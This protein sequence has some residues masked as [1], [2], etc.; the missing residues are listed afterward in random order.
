MRSQAPAQ[1]R[2]CPLTTTVPEGIPAALGGPTAPKPQ[3]KELNR[4]TAT[5][6]GAPSTWP[7]P[8]RCSH[9]LSRQDASLT[10]M[11]QGPAPRLCGPGLYSELD[12]TTSVLILSSIQGLHPE[13]HTQPDQ[14]RANHAWVGHQDGLPCPSHRVPGEGYGRRG[15]SDAVLTEHETLTT[16]HPTRHGG[17]A[18]HVND[19]AELPRDA[20][21]PQRF[22]PGL[23]TGGQPTMALVPLGPR[24]EE[25]LEGQM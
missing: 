17:S 12:Q 7:H 6:H 14:G 11:H 21:L 16:T 22:R 2:A 13:A 4:E 15:G 25:P 5:L 24:P 8:G 10:C 18:A 9:R 3:A 23:P 20:Q 19:R 1:P